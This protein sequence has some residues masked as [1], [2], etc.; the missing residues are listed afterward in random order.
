MG[1]NETQRGPFGWRGRECAQHVTTRSLA[2]A[3]STND[4]SRNARKPS[5]CVFEMAAKRSDRPEAI[6]VKE[7][8]RSR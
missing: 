6:N 1:L 7:K 4:V 5:A 8:S 3:A 2:D